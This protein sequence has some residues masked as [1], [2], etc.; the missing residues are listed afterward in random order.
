MQRVPSHQLLSLGLSSSRRVATSDLSAKGPSLKYNSKSC[1]LP[2][3]SCDW[4]NLP[5]LLLLFS[6][7]C[8][9][10]HWPNGKTKATRVCKRQKRPANN[11]NSSMDTS[12]TMTRYRVALALVS[13]E[14]MQLLSPLFLWE[15]N[16]F[17]SFD[18]TLHSSEFHS[19]F[20][21]IIICNSSLVEWLKYPSH[22]SLLAD[23]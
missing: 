15:K 10:I 22:F 11:C 12:L 21:A 3:A 16:S 23:C 1:D 5:L 9:S 19:N 13:S 17:F 7:S 4:L 6:I 8:F 14:S 20:G 2:V 18:S